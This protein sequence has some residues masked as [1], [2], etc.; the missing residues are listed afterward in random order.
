MT[1]TM[2]TQTLQTTAFEP[3]MAPANYTLAQET[4]LQDPCITSWF[5]KWFRPSRSDRPDRHDARLG[6]PVEA[7]AT[8]VP[9]QLTSSDVGNRSDTSQDD[10]ENPFPCRACQAWGVQCDRQT[11]RCAHCL[12]QQIL[13]FYVEPLRVTMKRERKSKDLPPTVP[14]DSVAS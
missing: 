13:C 14:H 6:P 11:P 2:A 5:S 4:A 7:S 3:S 8:Q 1:T 9:R 10:H 12:D